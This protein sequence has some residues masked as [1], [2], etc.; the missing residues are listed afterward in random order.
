MLLA[1]INMKGRA[2]EQMVTGRHAENVGM[3]S[4]SWTWLRKVIGQIL[5]GSSQAC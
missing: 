4:K 5:T 2:S 3:Q 1:I